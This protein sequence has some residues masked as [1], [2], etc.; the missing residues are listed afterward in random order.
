MSD[1]SR[2]KQIGALFE[3]AQ[4]RPADQRADFLRQACPGDPELCGEV[5]SLLK[6]AD[7]GDP[8]LDGSPLSSIAERPPALKPGDKLSV[9]I[10]PMRNGE[11]GGSFV[12]A[13][14]PDGQSVGMTGAITEP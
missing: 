2:W 14:R 12:S 3:A 13:K 6:A 11:K 4:Q 7:T 1:P 10:H 8:L 5:E 9:T